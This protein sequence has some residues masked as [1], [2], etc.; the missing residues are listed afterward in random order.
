MKS[1]ES[2]TI[3]I[4]ANEINRY[5]YCPYQWYYKRTYGQANLQRQYKA[6][7]ITSS[8]HENH[9]TRGT[10]HHSR[11]H[12]HYRAKKTAQGIFFFLMAAIALGGLLQ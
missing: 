4:A 10:K 6:L 9:Y 7:G 11:Y 5:V 8:K 1:H 2:T 3:K 12:R